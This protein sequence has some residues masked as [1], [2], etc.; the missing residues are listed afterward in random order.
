MDS[1]SIGAIFSLAQ[2]GR[3]MPCQRRK[4]F[5]RHSVMNSGSF[6]FD[7]IRRT[8]SSL[9]PGGIW[10]DSISVTKPCWYSL[11]TSASRVAVESARDAVEPAG[12]AV[13]PASVAVGL[14]GLLI[15]L[16][17]G[18]K[19]GIGVVEKNTKLVGY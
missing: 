6:F 19:R 3:V 14:D 12:V 7:E 8:T 1:K 2:S 15:A 4:A 13:G 11:C 18:G 9:R 10:S 17:C 16:T 5:S